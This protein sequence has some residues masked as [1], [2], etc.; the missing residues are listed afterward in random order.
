M[1]IKDFQLT[2]SLNK[3][4]VKNLSHLSVRIKDI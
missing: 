1:K 4:N 2:C 3:H